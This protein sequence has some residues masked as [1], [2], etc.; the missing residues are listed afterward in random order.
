M[1]TSTMAAQSEVLGLQS[2]SFGASSRTSPAAF[3]HEEYSYPHYARDVTWTDLALLANQFPS[4]SIRAETH[5]WVPQQ[6][7]SVHTTQHIASP[8]SSNSAITARRAQRH[9]NTLLQCQAS[10]ARQLSILL[11]QMTT[12]GEHCNG[13]Y[14]GQQIVAEIPAWEED[15]TMG[16]MDEVD[17]DLGRPILTYRRSADLSNQQGYVNKAVRIRKRRGGVDTGSSR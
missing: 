10:H 15:E 13:C 17:D 1:S 8:N 16:E 7:Q 2:Y 12:S 14:P 6:Q 9:A 5:E 11:E 3:S 4:H